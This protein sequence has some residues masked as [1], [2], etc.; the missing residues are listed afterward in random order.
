MYIFQNQDS[1]L[2]IITVRID[3]RRWMPMKWDILTVVL[4]ILDCIL[5]ILENKEK[6]N[7]ETG[8]QTE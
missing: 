4:K 7:N 6:E 1:W 5:I 2:G 3:D 8:S